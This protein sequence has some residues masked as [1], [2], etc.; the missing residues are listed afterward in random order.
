MSKYSSQMKWDRQLCSA[1][2]RMWAQVHPYDCWNLL[3]GV[4]AVV[5]LK[6]SSATHFS[7]YPGTHPIIILSGVLT[8]EERTEVGVLHYVKINYLVQL[9]SPQMNALWM[10][11]MN[12][13]VP[14]CI[15]TVSIISDYL[16]YMY[17][18]I[19][20]EMTRIL[21]C[22]VCLLGSK[23]RGYHLIPTNIKASCRLR[24]KEYTTQ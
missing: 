10:Q 1:S 5:F 13:S 7:N 18:Y 2:V 23:H 3:L 20:S 24:V 4:S 6:G 9:N 16:S 15:L 12:A 22:I 11:W 14:Q 8:R 19:S 21:H 17:L